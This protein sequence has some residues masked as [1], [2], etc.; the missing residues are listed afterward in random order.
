MFNKIL[1]DLNALFIWM[2]Q[3]G[4][5]ITAE[6]MAKFQ[7]FLSN[8][9]YSLTFQDNK[10]VFEGKVIEPY[11]SRIKL[12]SYKKAIV[13]PQIGE[14]IEIEFIRGRLNTKVL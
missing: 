14:A 10:F 9:G 11:H 7:Q 4:D 8:Y 13:Y 2:F 6:T 3:S 1:A 5:L 12:V